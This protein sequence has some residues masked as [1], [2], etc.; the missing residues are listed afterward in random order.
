MN[1]APILPSPPDPGWINAVSSGAMAVI[2][3]GSAIFGGIVGAIAGAFRAGRVSAEYEGRLAALE[4]KAIEHA[5]AL[6]TKTKE[7][8]DNL[9]RFGAIERQLAAQPTKADFDQM[10]REQRE[11][12]RQQTDLIMALSKRID[13]GMG[14]HQ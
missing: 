11:D 3:G 4:A 7:H 12:H 10:R 5:T 6:A 14:H 2:A 9:G 8:I 13:E 1:A